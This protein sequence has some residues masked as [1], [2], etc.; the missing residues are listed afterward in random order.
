MFKRFDPS[1]CSTSS[2]VKSSVQR[3]IKSKIVE[4]NSKLE[5]MIDDILPKK[6]PLVQYKNGPHITIYCKGSEVR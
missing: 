4:A 5:D 3:V 2:Q 1:E 6:P